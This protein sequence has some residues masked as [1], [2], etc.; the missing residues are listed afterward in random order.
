MNNWQDLLSFFPFVDFLS[1]FV[2]L[3]WN[4][5]RVN[6]YEQKQNVIRTKHKQR[7]DYFSRKNFPTDKLYLFCWKILGTWLGRFDNILSVSGA[8]VFLKMLNVSKPAEGIFYLKIVSLLFSVRGIFVEV[9]RAVCI[10]K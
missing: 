8:R 10:V 9:V 4:L 7:S 3:L 1:A 6:Y 2:L 5:L